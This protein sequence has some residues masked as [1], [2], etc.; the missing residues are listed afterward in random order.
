[1]ADNKRDIELRIAATTSGSEAI[2]KL[3]DVLDSLAKEAGDAGPKFTELADAV[4]RIGEQ[5][6]AV[7][8]LDRLEQQVKQTSE[9]FGTARERADALGQQL[10]EQRATTER[11]AVTQQKAQQAVDQTRQALI[12]NQTAL[13]NLNAQ[14]DRAGKATV[15]YKNQA[16]PLRETIRQLGLRLK[17]QR[18]DLEQANRAYS[19][20]STA[21][22]KIDSD[23]TKAAT[24]A[25]KL[26]KSLKQQNASLEQAQQ[27]LTQ[28]GVE[29]TQAATAIEKVEAALAG[30]QREAQQAEAAYKQLQAVTEAVAKSNERNVAIAQRAAAAREAAAQR[31][32]A[33]ERAAASAAEAA[34]LRS[35][36]AQQQLEGQLRETEAAQKSLNDAFAATGVRSAQAIESEIRQIVAS[37]AALRNNANVSGAEFDR[38]FKSA[39]T[40]V[41]ALKRELAGLPPLV[42]ETSNT[43]AILRQSFSQLTAA[44]G[45]FELGRGFIVANNQ[46]ETLRRSLTLVTGSTEEAQRQIALLRSVANDAGQSVGLVSDAFVRFQASLNGAGVPLAT[47]EAV[48]REVVNAAGQ[49]G[50]SSE[51]TSLVLDALAQ[52]AAKGTVSMEELRQQ[53]GDSLPGALSIAAKGLGVTTERLVELVETG[54]VTAEEFLPSFARALNDTFGQGERKVE[55]LA[56][57]W[58]RLR[59]AFNEFSSRASDTTTFRALVSLIDALAANFD[60]LVSVLGIAAQ[61]FAAFKI[62]EY[63]RNFG[64]LSSAIGKSKVETDALTAS[65]RAASTATAADTAVKQANTAATVA[66]TAAQAAN[67][68]AWVALA[69]DLGQVGPAAANASKQT[70]AA[71]ASSGILG[72]AFGALS[73]ATRGLVGLIGGLPGVL[74]IVALNA[75]ELGTGIANLAARFTG[76]KDRLDAANA[77]LKAQED[78]ERAAAEQAARLAREQAAAEKAALGLTDQAAKLVDQFTKVQKETGSA[79]EALA[80]LSKEL[81]FDDLDGI[82]NA[83][84]ALNALAATGKAS[85]EQIKQAYTE[86]L[87]GKDLLVFETNARTAFDNIRGGAEQLK[88]VTDA[89]GQESLRRV[90][91]SVQEVQTGF[92]AAFNSATNDTNILRQTLRDL[93]ADSQQASSLLSQAFDKELELANTQKAIE[94]V[95]AR[96]QD[97]ARSGVDVEASLVKAI[98]KSIE[99]AD[100]DKDL[101]R[102]EDQIRAIVAANPAMA[103]AFEDSLERVK[104]KLAEVSPALKQLADDAKRLGVTLGESTNSGVESSLRAYERLKASGKL[105]TDQLR[106][107]FVNVAN[108]A[109]RAAGG[110]VP[111]WVKVEAAIRGVEIATNDAGEAVVQMAQKGTSAL[112]QLAGQIGSVKKELQETKKLVDGDGFTTDKNGNRIS[113]YGATWLSIFNQLKGYGLDDAQARSI[114]GEFTDS[115]GNVQFTNNP[116]QLKY[117]GQN[118]TLDFAILKAAEQAIRRGTS[119]TSGGGAQLSPSTVNVNLNGQRTSVG[120]ASPEEAAKLLTIFSAINESANR[121]GP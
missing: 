117:G 44:F 16:D 115:N 70:A 98:E 95:V 88:I 61:A 75:R 89:I 66:N 8:V 80:A 35:R 112:N 71:A 91:T 6:D 118:S 21:L 43:A 26:D 24:A 99:F 22:R 30:T 60:R 62:V 73:G 14:Y 39:E 100:T 74:A 102:V 78:A 92:S 47:T 111:E 85:A 104:T 79:S 5:G 27:Q 110:Q 46:L 41:E 82:R 94:E 113:A 52:I 56:A 58:N 84:I 37:L 86:A 63:V 64:S 38:A 109:I 97:A 49:L 34:A 53:L 32:V 93:G 7:A 12:Q 106:E 45:A 17:Q 114:A 36:L 77:A 103:K 68:T 40:R 72:R 57:A 13:S 108:D 101:K 9:S 48:F 10:V 2:V 20:Q 65:T 33:A 116:G 19:E 11:F 76:L 15:G 50:Q 42:R 120:L 25:G 121:S 119:G 105:T 51:R 28:L 31:Q 59:N 4:R 55:S 18:L 1:M 54:Q 96:L 23:Y 81:R 29:S 83:G 90:G 69:A 87:D 3:S 67:R 107:A